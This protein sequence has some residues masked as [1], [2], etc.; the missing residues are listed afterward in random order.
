[1]KKHTDLIFIKVANED[2]WV[3]LT[4]KLKKDLEPDVM[5]TRLEVDIL[6][7]V[8]DKISGAY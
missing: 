2:I 3:Y 7:M 8:P 5:D 4:M 1:M 6:R